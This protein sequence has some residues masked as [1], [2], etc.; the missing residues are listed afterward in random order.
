[1]GDPEMAPLGAEERGAFLTIHRLDCMAVITILSNRAGLEALREYRRGSHLG[2]DRGGVLHA[3]LATFR[4]VRVEG[5][6][7]F[8]VHRMADAHGF[9]TLPFERG[10]DDGTGGTGN[11]CMSGGDN[12]T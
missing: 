5:L 11:A 1:M 12:R 7:F 9:A 2:L 8:D 4:G 6:P 10:G 3:V